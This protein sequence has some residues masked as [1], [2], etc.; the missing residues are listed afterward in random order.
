[1]IKIEASW[2]D[3]KNSRAKFKLPD[4]EEWTAA[5]I[6]EL[7]DV[8]NQIRA[9]MT[10]AV[11]SEPPL[12]QTVP[13]LDNP[14][15]WTNLDEFSGG[16]ALLIRHPSL[17]WLPFLFPSHERKKISVFLAKQEEEFQKKKTSH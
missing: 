17:G 13:A 14:A 5:E 16:T 7:M 4:Q 8:L 1:M 11:P 9:V 15:W 10:P 3:D 6:V 12:F 2:L